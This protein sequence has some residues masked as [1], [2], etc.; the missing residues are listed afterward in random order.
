M[1]KIKLTESDLTRIITKVIKEQER[2]CKAV[3]RDG[4]ESCDK[5]TKN[6]KD[7]NEALKKYKACVQEVFKDYDT[8]K[9]KKAIKEQDEENYEVEHE[10][11]YT[12]LDSKVVDVEKRLTQLEDDYMRKIG[13]GDHHQH[14]PPL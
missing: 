7:K 10:F 14:P 11:N 3:A 9:G 8:C 4:F 5:H 12:S 2:D 13:F 6:K 1:K